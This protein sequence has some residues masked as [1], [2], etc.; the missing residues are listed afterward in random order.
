[1]IDR[2]F[3]ALDQLRAR[4][5]ALVHNYPERL[6]AL[7]AVLAIGGAG[8]S[9]AV[10]QL[11]DDDLRIPS[12]AVVEVVEP[13]SVAAQ[14]DALGQLS[15]NLYR[16]TQGRSGDSPDALLKRLGLSDPQALQALHN[17]AVFQKEVLGRIGRT[18]IAQAQ[19]GK[20]LVE[21]TARWMNSDS[22][23]GRW[24]LRKT[25][26]AF[27]SSLESLPL[28]P[29]T[30]LGSGTITANLFAAT[31]EARIPDSVAIQL[32]EI[33]SGDIDFHRL[34]KGDRFSVVY[35]TLMGDDEPLGVGRVL[36]AEFVAGGKP[37][38]ALWFRNPQDPADSGAYYT[39]Q[40]QSLRRAFLASPMEFSRVTS[41]F[42]MRFHPILQT[43][44]AHLGVDYGAAV[45]TPARTVADGVVSFSG[46]QNGYGNVVFVQ[47]NASQT[48]VYAHLSKLLVRT[49]EKIRQGQTI[50]LVGATG[51][52]T[53]P[54]LHF[55]FR[56][57]GA[58]RDPQKIAQGAPSAPVSQAMR[59]VF[60]REAQAAKDQLAAAA[61][62][63]QASA[64]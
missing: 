52:A 36:S 57:N 19:D 59:T 54:H 17:D 40:G 37:L 13:L 5:A 18:V 11:D 31:D 33:F 9:F 64:Q 58:H 45:G 21:L 27:A 55:E 51:W 8:A 12:T 29:S 63:T 3:D 53:G 10:A 4:A 22:T 61:L 16:S 43:W 38:Q 60:L 44:R 26:D 15:Q 34:H 14:I 50:G 32:A 2:W 42:A 47:H 46:V 1:L 56:V 24:T 35:E 49:G 48:T 30:R 41:G 28:V 6:A 62:V 25:G 7:V 23:F 20:Y 39:L